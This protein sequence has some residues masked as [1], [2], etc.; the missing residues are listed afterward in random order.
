MVPNFFNLALCNGT[1]RMSHTGGFKGPN[2]TYLD[3]IRVIECSGMQCESETFRLDVV[4]L[5]IQAYQ[6]RASEPE[7]ISQDHDGE[8]QDEYSSQARV[9]PLPNMELDGI[10]ESYDIPSVLLSM[11]TWV[12]FLDSCL[13]SRYTQI[14]FMQSVECV[15][16]FSIPTRLSNKS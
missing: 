8:K 14:C 2:S 1:N 11:V 3:S 10:W 5:D 4:N 13:T 12:N 7:N 15:S 6:L 16:I 9:M